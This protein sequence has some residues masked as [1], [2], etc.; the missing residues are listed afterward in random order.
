MCVCVCVCEGRRES[1]V[2]VCVKG[3][4]RV[5]CVCVQCELQLPCVYMYA[6]AIPAESVFLCYCSESMDDIGRWPRVVGGGGGPVGRDEG[7]R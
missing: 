7:G 6:E 3:E 2:C 1:V 5:L 4:G